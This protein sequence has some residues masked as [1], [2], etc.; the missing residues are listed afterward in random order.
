MTEKE[1]NIVYK[2]LNDEEELEF[3]T[4]SKMYNYIRE[5]QKDNLE[6]KAHLYPNES[7]LSKKLIKI[8][9]EWLTENAS[10]QVGLCGDRSCIRCRL[11]DI[12]LEIEA[13]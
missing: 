4:S 11:T 12:L 10:P 1:M 13:I 9:M 5:L 3:E 7:N 2:C 6:L 8:G